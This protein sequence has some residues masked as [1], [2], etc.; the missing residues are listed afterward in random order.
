MFPPERILASL[1]HYQ[2]EARALVQ[3]LRQRPDLI[4]YAKGAL[5]D[6]GQWADYE[7]AEILTVCAYDPIRF[8]ELLPVM[9]LFVEEIPPE[10]HPAMPHEPHHRDT[11]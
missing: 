4:A 7:I 2:P 11:E 8:A 6:V 1:E 5:F 3:L 10:H 9:E